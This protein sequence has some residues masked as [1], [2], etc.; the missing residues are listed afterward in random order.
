MTDEPPAD[1]SRTHALFPFTSREVERL[2]R[3]VKLAEELKEFRYFQQKEPRKLRSSSQAGA[4]PLT[5]DIP[6]MKS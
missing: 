5:F 2:R 1:F 6:R 4:R 3:Y